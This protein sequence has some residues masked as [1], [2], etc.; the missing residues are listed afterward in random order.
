MKTDLHARG[1]PGDSTR[2]YL[3]GIA[4]PK[5]DDDPACLLDELA[6]LAGNLQIDVAARQI[7]T[8]RQ[9]SPR[10]YIGT[11]KAQQIKEEAESLA[12]DVVIFD[13]PLAPA[14]QRNLEELFGLRVADRQE[15]I[16]DI[17]AERAQ[18][19]EAVLQVELARAQYMLARIR[20]YWGHLNRQ[21]GGGVTQRGEGESQGEIDARM[22][23]ERIAKLKEELAAVV[24]HRQVQRK[25]RER[26]PLPSAAIVGYTNAGKSSLLNALTGS[27][28]GAEDKLFATLDPTTRQMTTPTGKILLTDTVG[29]VRRLPHRL[30]ESF[31]A[32][33]EEALVADV[34]IHV[35]DASQPDIEKRRETTLAVLAELG[36]ADKPTITL[37]NK[38]DLVPHSEEARPDGGIY[39]STRTGEGLGRLRDTLM[40]LTSAGG[41][42]RELLIPHGHHDV[43]ASLYQ[44]ACVISRE[45]CDE[46]VRIVCVPPPR[47]AET[48]RRY[49]IR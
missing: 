13:I 28:V 14:Q 41:G 45:D 40:A 1:I 12:C 30:V 24:R 44:S 22:T 19:R 4:E 43:V 38:A 37:Y 46:G 10:Y 2:A 8:I 42:V 21:R 17:F 35:I 20:G 16:L 9:P 49:D 25:R 3:V 26:V 33:L 48:L 6:E 7:V 11:G 36:A 15:V 47:L 29:F 31:K 5:M 27:S 23:R 18:T 34:L 39:A 32:T